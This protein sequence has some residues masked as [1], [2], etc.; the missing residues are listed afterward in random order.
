MIILIYAGGVWKK[1]ISLFFNGRKILHDEEFKA[2]SQKVEETN[3][4]DF[5]I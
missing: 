5:E 3:Y 2:S 1:K 4:K